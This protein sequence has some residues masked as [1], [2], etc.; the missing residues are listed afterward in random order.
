MPA[1]AGNARA[2]YDETASQKLDRLI[3]LLEQGASGEDRGG[4]KKDTGVLRIDF[5][6]LL[7]AILARYKIILL[8]ALAMAVGMGFYAT[9]NYVPIYRSSSMLYLVDTS[10]GG[11]ITSQLLSLGNSVK[12]DYVEL[13]RTWEVRE[14]VLQKLKLDYS[15]ATLDAGVTITA[16]DTSRMINISATGTDPE[17][18]MNI[19]NAYAE[20]AQEYIGEIMG[21]DKPSI[22]SHARRGTLINSSN[23][24][25]AVIRGFLIGG[26]AVALIFGVIYL[27]D[28][29]VR[30]PDDIVYAVDLPVMGVIPIEEKEK[31]QSASRKKRRKRK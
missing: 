26:G 13:L 29:R 23:R 14:R 1:A 16:A 3:G 5:L 30:T 28:D 25:N 10:G 9:R 7:Y 17:R 2:S 22:A 8:C 4:E 15:Y 31:I 24:R 18:S 12:S 21:G 27:V 11:G 20:V 19:A 6:G